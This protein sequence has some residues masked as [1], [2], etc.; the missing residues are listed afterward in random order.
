MLSV[1]V[2]YIV[3]F[4]IAPSSNMEFQVKVEYAKDKWITF[5]VSSHLVSATEYRFIDLVEDITSRCMTLNYLT[6]M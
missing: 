1:I 3:F 2:V 4:H 5:M 6:V